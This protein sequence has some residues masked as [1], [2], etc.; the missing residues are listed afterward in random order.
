MRDLRASITVLQT[1][2]SGALA[3]RIL[4]STY[5]V[6][7]SMYYVCN[8]RAKSAFSVAAADLAVTSVRSAQLIQSCRTMAGSMQ[9]YS[10]L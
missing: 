7:H 4:D 5:V 2:S 6:V 1:V 8:Y 10:S 9:N 3:L